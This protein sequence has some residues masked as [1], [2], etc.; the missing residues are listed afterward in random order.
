MT[1]VIVRPLLDPVSGKLTSF[2]DG[3]AR[4][5]KGNVYTFINGADIGNPSRAFAKP[6]IDAASVGSL[7]ANANGF[8]FDQPVGGAFAVAN[9][10][11]RGKVLYSSNPSPSAT[12]RFTTPAALEPQSKYY[13]S[14]WIRLYLGLSGSMYPYYFQHKVFRTNSLN[15][16]NDNTGVQTR[17]FEQNGGGSNALIVFSKDVAGNDLSSPTYSP[18][19]SLIPPDDTW[20]FIEV[21]Q[22]NSDD[23][24]ANARFV[25][26]VT[27]AG[28][29]QIGVNK[30][31]YINYYDSSQRTNYL[32]EQ[33]YLGNF[34][35]TPNEGTSPDTKR[36]SRDSAVYIQDWVRYDVSDSLSTQTATRRQNLNYTNSGADS[37]VTIDTTGWPSGDHTVYIRKITGI[38]SN[39]W[40]VVGDYK[41]IIIRV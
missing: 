38:D 18:A 31:N 39:G 22:Q 27:K 13:Y 1:S 6:L 34:G 4:Y 14:F 29:T 11:T 5:V 26:R 40:D 41:Q 10:A 21:F 28:A 20:A 12:F 35:I 16:I 24:V 8:I 7:P 2:S 15:D 3:V 25:Y 36:F 17:C 33:G 37:L 30:T 23:N 32:I 19:A 9:D